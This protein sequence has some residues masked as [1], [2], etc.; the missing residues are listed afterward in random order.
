MEALHQERTGTR[1]VPE[2]AAKPAGGFVLVPAWAFIAAWWACRT[3]DLCPLDLR[4]W[5]ASFEAVARRCGGSQGVPCGVHDRR[6]AGA[7]GSGV[8]P[9][10]PRGPTAAR[11]R[12]PGRVVAGR[13]TLRG[14]SRGGRAVAAGPDARRSQE[15]VDAYAAGADA[16]A[17]GA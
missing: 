4:V 8:G 11:P 14:R 13:T 9:V 6:A 16:A 10:G 15:G 17:A 3:G 12:R 5:L 1:L 2:L 7:D